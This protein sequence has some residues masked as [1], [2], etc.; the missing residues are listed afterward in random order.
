M[1]HLKAYRIWKLFVGCVECASTARRARGDEAKSVFPVFFACVV[2]WPVSCHRHASRFI[3]KACSHRL[4]ACEF[5]A[6][7]MRCQRVQRPNDSKPY[8]SLA[9]SQTVTTVFILT[10]DSYGHKVTLGFCLILPLRLTAPTQTHPRPTVF[11]KKTRFSLVS[12]PSSPQPTLH[13]QNVVDNP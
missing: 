8:S 11:S 6:C 9:L 1:V 12:P 10:V 7:P 3:R 4:L 5:D 2:L 13:I